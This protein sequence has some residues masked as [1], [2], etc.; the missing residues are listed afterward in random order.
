MAP[1]K[2]MELITHQVPHRSRVVGALAITS[3]LSCF[4]VGPMIPFIILGLALLGYYQAA[5][6]TAGVIATSMYLAG[7][8]TLWCRFYLRAAGWFQKGVFIH[9]EPRAINAI[10][11]NTSMW[12]MHPHGVF[13][14]FGFS[15][16]GAVRLRAEKEEEYLPKEFNLTIERLRSCNGVQAP[17]LFKV[18]LIRSALMGFGCATPATKQAMHEL[19]R[20]NIDFGI[21]PGGMEEVALYR[22]GRE[23]VYLKNR[24][25]FIKYAL[26]YGYLVQPGYTFGECDMYTSL[27][28]GSR[29]RMWMLK[30]YGFVI[31]VFWG[32][33]WLLPHLPRSDIPLHTVVGSPLKL[34]VIKEPTNEQVAEWH[35][36]YIACVKE[37]FD[38]YKHRFGYGDR[39]LE[40]K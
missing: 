16:N 26:Q 33:N 29:L 2:G 39:E 21:L 11:E 27:E 1:K 37:V 23:R 13:V 35:G 22:K 7:H 32:P 14:G 20:K 28:S 19:F 34:P 6:T 17:V 24:A 40:I 38:T 25:G 36:K 5:A 30:K 4:A 10:Q 18:P 12:C 15:L 8:S 9:F 31:P 3:M